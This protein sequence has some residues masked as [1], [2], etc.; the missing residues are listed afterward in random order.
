MLARRYTKPLRQD[1]SPAK[2]GIL[3]AHGHAIFGLVGQV[4]DA[5]GHFSW[6]FT[7][8]TAYLQGSGGTAVGRN[9]RAGHLNT[10]SD[11]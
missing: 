1:A 9:S 2:H 11:P 7:F 10:G 5:L 6:P 4:Y 8:W 3:P